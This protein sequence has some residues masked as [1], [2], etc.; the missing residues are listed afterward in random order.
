MPFCLWEQIETPMTTKV[1]NSGGALEA[2]KRMHALGRIGQP[3]DVAK[4]IEFLLHPENSFI[5]GQ[6]LGVDGGLGA[7][8]PP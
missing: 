1:T 7:V 3:S 6:V 2:S 4:L 8:S 5:T